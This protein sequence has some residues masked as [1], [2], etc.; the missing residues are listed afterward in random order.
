MPIFKKGNHSISLAEGSSYYVTAT[1]DCAEWYICN[2]KKPATYEVR[3]ENGK[4]VLKLKI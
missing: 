2:I 3:C 1:P 4:L